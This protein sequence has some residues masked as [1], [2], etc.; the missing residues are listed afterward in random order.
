VI[1]FLQYVLDGLAVGGLYALIAVG[2][3]MVYGVLQMI[4]FAHGELFM[5]GAYFV[6]VVLGAGAP[7]WAAIPLCAVGIGLFA[8]I[9][10]RIAYRPLRGADRLAP[11]ITAVGVSLFLQYSVQLLFSPNPRSYPIQLTSEMIELFDGA[12]IVRVRDIGIFAFTVLITIALE[13]FV[14]HTKPGKG[15]RALAMHP[16]AARFVGVPIDRTIALTFFI[17]AALACLAGSLQGMAVNQIGPFMGVTTGLK[18]FAAAVLGGIGVLPGALLGGLVLG[19]TENLLVGYELST[20]KDGSAFL[21]LILV[22]LIR[23][24]GLL[25]SSRTVKV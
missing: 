6:M 20:Y 4:N 24:Q 13:V 9:I 12:V 15:I 10:E 18:A 11:L 2:Y 23:P 14:R 3:S 1:D 7:A 25:G 8:V 22:L 17:G 21:I 5:V 16:M 19:I